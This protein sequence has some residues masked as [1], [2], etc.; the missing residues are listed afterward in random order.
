MLISG[1]IFLGTYIVLAF[2]RLPGLRIDRTGAAIIGAFG[3]SAYSASKHALR[4][5]SDVLR[6]QNR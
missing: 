3:Y 4:G 2:G 5:L 6:P 1:L